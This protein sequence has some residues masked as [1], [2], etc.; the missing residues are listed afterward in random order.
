M[1]K[2]TTTT[3][4]TAIPLRAALLAIAASAAVLLLLG[5]LHVLSPEFDPSWRMVSEYANGRY[6]WVLS[7]MFA[8]WAVSSWALAFMLRSQV[9]TTSGKIGLFFLITAGLGEAMASVFD[10]N[11]GLHDLAGFIGIG[12]LPMAAMLISMSL[13]HTAA[14]STA[15]KPLLWTANLTWISIVL[16]IVS[17]IVMIVTYIQSGGDMN[18]TAVP[19]ALPVGVIAFVGWTNRLLIMAYCT[20]VMTVG[21]LAMQVRGNNPRSI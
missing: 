12:G 21:W 1:S 9:T 4:V 13:S 16:L 2:D 17:F 10:I 19:T 5:S 11:H 8:S 7:L 15:K 18:T 6:G 3:T 14:W 20:W